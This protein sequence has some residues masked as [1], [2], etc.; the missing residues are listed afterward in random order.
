MDDLSVL[1][2]VLMQT[3]SAQGA[4]RFNQIMRDEKKGQKEEDFFP[5]EFSF[6]GFETS[7]TLGLGGA[8]A[9]AGT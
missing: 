1:R 6:P 7:Q 3:K 5:Q 9:L 4:H 2:V 8:R